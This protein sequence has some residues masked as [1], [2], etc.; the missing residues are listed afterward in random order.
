V[1][2]VVA[3]TDS[4]AILASKDDKVTLVAQENY[5]GYYK[6]GEQYIVHVTP[7]VPLHP[8]GEDSPEPQSAG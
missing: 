6:Q 4:H 5:D 2:A 7:F 8:V 1:F 3:A